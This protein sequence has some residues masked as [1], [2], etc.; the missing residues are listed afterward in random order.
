MS[1]RGSGRKS[2]NII[3]T[4]ALPPE[5]APLFAHRRL[6]HAFRQFFVSPNAVTE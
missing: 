5:Q 1:L 6:G 4:G 3:S 2:L